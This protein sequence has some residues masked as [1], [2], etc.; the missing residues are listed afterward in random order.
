MACTNGDSSD[1]RKS[2]Q[3]SSA[4][5]SMYRSVISR[6]LRVDVEKVKD[7]LHYLTNPRRLN[8]LCVPLRVYKNAT[9]PKDILNR[10]FPTYINPEDT[11]VLEEIV[12]EFGSRCCKKELQDYIDRFL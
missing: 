4:F 10:F 8:E 5:N 1:L 7:F 3:M 12:N 11:F 6:L 2:W 9:T